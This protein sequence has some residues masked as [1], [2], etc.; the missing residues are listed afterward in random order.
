M[1][2]AKLNPS[3]HHPHHHRTCRRRSVAACCRRRRRQQHR[4]RGRAAVVPRPRDCST[5]TGAEPSCPSYARSPDNNQY[6]ITALCKQLMNEQTIFS[7]HVRY[8]LSPVRPSVVC[9]SV[10]FVH[11]T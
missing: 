1:F 10:T 8:M 3:H 11:P 9:L 7:V 5:L 6:I 4:R 2:D